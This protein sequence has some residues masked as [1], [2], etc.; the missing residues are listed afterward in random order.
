MKTRK[1][2]TAFALV[3]LAT[4]S[5]TATA[6]DVRVIGA[7]TP[8]ACTATIAGGGTLD[9]GNINPL[10]LSPTDYTVLS[11]RVAG[12]SIAC[13]APAKVALRAVNRRPGTAAGTTDTGGGQGDGRA[14]VRIFGLDW[15]G[16]AGLGLADGARIG[17]YGI[18]ITPGRT[19][20]D[21]Q[22]VDSLR[23]SNISSNWLRDEYSGNLYDPRFTRV[24]S[25][26]ATGTL[27]PVAFT[28]LSGEL[29]VQAYINRTSELDL[30]QPVVLDGLT[31]IEL[32]YL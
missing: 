10:N 32:V 18:R 21:G 13:D 24:N 22:P 12:F 4:T 16:V 23:A 17:G 11:E 1:L 31:T 25:W 5:L 20:A 3:A 6:T 7:I 19:Q 14:P 8:P 15:V 2:P 28:A 26:G 27:L 30:R 29:S 9:Y